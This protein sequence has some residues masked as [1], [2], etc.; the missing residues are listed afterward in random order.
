MKTKSEEDD[1]HEEKVRPC[2]EREKWSKGE[3]RG[4]Q[5]QLRDGL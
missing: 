4:V 2:Y 1:D 3:W 5:G